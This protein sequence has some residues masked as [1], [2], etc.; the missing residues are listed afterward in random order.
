M[1]YPTA[2]CV[3]YGRAR[4]EGR[5]GA[6]PASAER[7]RVRHGGPRPGSGGSGGSSS[8][9]SSSSRHRIRKSD[10]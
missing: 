5:G 1:S 7:A 4:Q 3:L 2:K 9:G 10:V 8:S 6:R